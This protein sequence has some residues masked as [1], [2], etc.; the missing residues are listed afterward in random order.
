MNKEQIE[1]LLNA[2]F[3]M[4]EIMSRF[5]TPAPSPVLVSD[6]CP[7]PPPGPTPAP[8]PAPEPTPAPSP[9]P[10]PDPLSASM[11]AIESAMN[12]IAAMLRTGALAAQFGPPTPDRGVSDILAEVINPP[13][14][15]A[16]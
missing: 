16:K 7:P 10:T 1:F 4:E 15:N 5:S 14:R 9:A 8:S 2:G 13:R 3:S 6:P 11:A 12:E